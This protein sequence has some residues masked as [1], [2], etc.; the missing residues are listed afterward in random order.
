MA[1]PPDLDLVPLSTPEARFSAPQ[2]VA[3][4]LMAVFV[5][6]DYPDTSDEHEDWLKTYMVLRRIV[7]RKNKNGFK[8]LRRMKRDPSLLQ[9]AYAF[10]RDLLRAQGGL[11]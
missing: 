6:A 9:S 8:S 10:T 3:R 2:E 5:D 7:E 11:L 4:G 1:A